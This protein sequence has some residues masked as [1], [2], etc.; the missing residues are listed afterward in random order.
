MQFCVQAQLPAPKTRLP[1]EKP[2]PEDKALTRWEKFALERGIR[3]RKKDRM[4]WDEAAQ[5]W[6][7]AWGYKVREAPRRL[8]FCANRHLSSH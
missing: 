3:K 1:R 8:Y 2:V 5:E 4:A 6:R 7:P